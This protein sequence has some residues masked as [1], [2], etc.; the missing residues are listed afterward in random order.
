MQ[1]VAR[2]PASRETVFGML[3]SSARS[4]SYHELSVLSAACGAIALAAAISGVA[5][6]MLLAACYIAWSFAGW[7]ILFH[8]EKPPLGA[9]RILHLVIVGSAATVAVVL[10]VGVFFW[11]LGPRWML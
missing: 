1:H 6:W 5:S 9:W 10:G 7:G 8:S 3:A 2:L 4:L 11:A